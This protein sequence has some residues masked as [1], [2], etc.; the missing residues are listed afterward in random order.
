MSQRHD[1]D[2]GDSGMQPQHGF[3]LVRRDPPVERLE[4][5]VPAS[6]QANPSVRAH[7]RHVPGA[8]P[9]ASPDASGP[10]GVVE[11][12]GHHTDRP[13]RQ[14]HAQLAASGAVGIFHGDPV[15]R[16]R[17]ANPARSWP[18]PGCGAD[19]GGRLS[20]AVTITDRHLPRAAD[21]VGEIRLKRLA[22]TER[23]TQRRACRPQIRAHP[24]PHARRRAEGI[25]TQLHEQ[26]WQLSQYECF[27]TRRDDR[28]FGA[29]RDKKTAP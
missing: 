15:T 26:A 12:A 10:L 20:L 18:Q 2:I 25:D 11:I 5:L 13:R 23:L 14:V 9:A 6:K 24:A 29:P 16:E 27:R 19:Q 8:V 3:D 17:F 28:G 1:R 7:L 21:G 4:H 22:G